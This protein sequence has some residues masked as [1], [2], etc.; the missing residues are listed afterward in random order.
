M[1]KIISIK[2]ED[3]NEIKRTLAQSYILIKDKIEEKT[4]A[5]AG[6]TLFNREEVLSKIEK[7]I[8][9]IEQICIDKDVESV[10]NKF[11]D[12]V[13]SF[14]INGHP[15]FFAIVGY[16]KSI[17]EIILRLICADVST[18]PFEVKEVLTNI[19]L[20]KNN[21]NIKVNDVYKSI[22][23]IFGSKVTNYAKNITTKELFYSNLELFKEYI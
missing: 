20:L 17:N 8:G 9:I 14:T 2:N 4:I 1:E 22:L 7:E 15:Y 12:K 3:L 6:D 11:K 10:Y 16:N 23:D 13:V 5:S 21:C 19:D 18:I